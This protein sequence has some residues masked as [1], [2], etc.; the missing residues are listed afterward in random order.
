MTK[1]SKIALQ[2]ILPFLTLA[3]V[4]VSVSSVRGHDSAAEQLQALFAEEWSFRLAENP[5][6][7]TSVGVHDFDDRLP[8]VRRAD[9]ARRV[10]V[11]RGFLERLAAIDRGQLSEGDLVSY[12][13]FERQL[14]GFVEEFE[15]HHDRLPLLVDSG[16]H[17]DFARLPGEMPFA[18]AKDYENYIARLR[19]FPAYMEQHVVLLKD[20]LEHGMTLP[21]VVLEGYE[22]TI[23]SHVV[24]TPEASLFYGPFEKFP[25]RLGEDERKR[26]RASGKAAI[27]EAVVPGY[28]RFLKFMLGEYIP[29][30]RTTL[31]ASEFPNGAAYYDQ[32]I[33]H[34][35]TL[36]LSAQ[37]IHD[38]GLREVARIR[39]EMEKIVEEVAF[40]GDFADFLA[41]LRTDPR[42]Y[43]KTPEEL[44]K[45]ASYLAKRADAALPA[46][47]G[48]L[49]R[50][51]YG[52]APVPDHL[53]PK[54]TGGRYLGTSPGSTQPGYYWVNTYALENRPLY[55]LPALTLHEAVPGHHLQISLNQELADLPPFRRYSYISAFGEGWGLYAEWLGIEM[56]IY[57]TPYSHFG[58]LTYE[59][60]RACRLVVDTG[61][62]AMGWTRQQAMDF[63]AGNTALSLHEVRTETDRYISWPAQALSYKL[64]ELKIRELRR[65][66]EETLGDH[67]DLR[68]FHDVVLSNGSIPLSVLEEVVDRYLARH[69]AK[70][71]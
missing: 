19:A 9:E 6:L 27:Q 35:T 21:R 69:G 5:L 8:S 37:E 17:I 44:L 62:H 2:W 23:D 38:L 20:G 52:V 32:R 51:P 67:F 68:E 29:G 48:V 56:G 42:F 40:E 31:G 28:R 22:V 53:A 15:F 64:G 13:V 4:S 3:S 18:T 30:A 26:L 66:A 50:T 60:W 36:E 11:W 71:G 25:D 49:P 39:A 55:V 14:R 59:M 7:A 54:Y 70:E 65:R 24:D 12:G 1:S 47:F 46:F 61:L 16:F 63:L 43:A 34:F 57:D 45:E 41:F 58:R 33:R 10:E